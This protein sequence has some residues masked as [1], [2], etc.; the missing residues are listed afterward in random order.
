MQAVGYADK[1]LSAVCSM[2]RTR[3]PVKE[4]DPTVHRRMEWPSTSLQVI[5]F[6]QGCSKQAHFN[7]LGTGYKY[8]STELGCILTVLRVLSVIHPLGNTRLAR[9]IQLSST[10]KIGQLFTMFWLSIP[11][12]QVALA[13]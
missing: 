4:R 1:T 2:A 6:N 9:S 11:S 5:D 3:S 8:E 13:M 7:K 12:S 10:K